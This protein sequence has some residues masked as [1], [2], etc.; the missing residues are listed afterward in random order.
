MK[1]FFIV[2]FLISLFFVSCDSDAAVASRNVSQAADNFEIYRRVIFV[3]GITDN[4]LLLI[5][6]YCSVEFY[7]EKFVVTVKVAPGV[8]LKHYMGA[9]DNVFPIVEQLEPSAVSDSHYRVIF[10]PSAIIPTIDIR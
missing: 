5:E 7:S 1:K 3:N 9:A 6:G 8:Y 10:K 2:L 4:Y